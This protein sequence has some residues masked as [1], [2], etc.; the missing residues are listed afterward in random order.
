MHVYTTTLFVH[1]VAVSFWLGSQLFMLAVVVP[2]LRGTEPRQ[3]GALLRGVG[4]RYA[5]VSTPTLLIILVTGA[6][7]ASDLQLFS[8]RGV[9]PQARRRGGRARLHRGARD[10]RSQA[11]DAPVAHLNRRHRHRDARRGLVRRAHLSGHPLAP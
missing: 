10:R 1:L 11:D 4:Q 7:L 5:M 9:R 8:G 2:A 6:L 3:R